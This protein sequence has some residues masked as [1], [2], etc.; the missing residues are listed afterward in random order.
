[1]LPPEV[2]ES[3]VKF[4]DLQK[5][6]SSAPD[7]LAVFR[8]MGNF[9]RKE[10]E[11]IDFIIDQKL[12]D[13]TSVIAEDVLD[14]IK[15]IR[16]KG[17]RPG[18]R[19]GKSVKGIAELLKLTN[20][21]FGKGTLK[22]ADDIEPSEFAKFNER[23]RKLTDDEYAEL[24][25]IYG[26]G[27]PQLETVADAEKF[28]AGQ[29]AYEAAMFTDYKAGRLDPK[30]GEKG[31]KRFLEKKAEEAEMSGD[32]RLFTPD[33]ADE[34][35]MLEASS[36]A[37][38]ESALGAKQYGGIKNAEIPM[39]LMTVDIIKVKY[40]QIPDEMAE[41]IASLPNDKKALAIADLEQAI[42]LQESGR[43]SDEIIEIMKSEPKTKM[44]KGGLA[45]ILEM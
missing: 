11:K 27:L 1:M 29:K 4:K 9:T 36:P 14:Y 31:R 10:L 38:V 41:M 5:G 13:D 32:S 44:K 6:G 33:E 30:P 40:P 39:E 22:T 24:E 8:N 15:E 34:L 7:P 19:S 25:E 28:V 26:E 20:K 18:F 21:K 23:N 17:F 35:T 2:T 45:Q 43:S 37:N 42:M 3:I 12:F 16:P